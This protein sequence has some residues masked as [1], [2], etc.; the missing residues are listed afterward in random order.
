MSEI[1]PVSSSPASA[2]I[3]AP[4]LAAVEAKKVYERTAEQLI[5]SVAPAQQDSVQISPQAQALLAAS[6]PPF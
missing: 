6:R 5:R 1:S 4:S 3:S 2:P